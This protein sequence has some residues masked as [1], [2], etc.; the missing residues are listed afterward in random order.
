MKEVHGESPETLRHRDLALRL[1]SGLLHTY[2]TRNPHDIW[3]FS[4]H[5]LT[6]QLMLSLSDQEDTLVNS[7]RRAEHLANI[8]S[9]IQ[10][11]ALNVFLGEAPL[12]ES[13]PIGESLVSGLQASARYAR[14]LFMLGL[15]AFQNPGPNNPGPDCSGSR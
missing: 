10:E 3:T 4:G 13:V 14:S 7:R 5:C 11:V 2:V 6:E 1:R 9:D 8:E 12:Q 15:D